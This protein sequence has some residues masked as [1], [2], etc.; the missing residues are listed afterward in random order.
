MDQY[1]GKLLDNRYEILDAI[2]VGGM[3]MVYKAYCHR[4]HRLVAV[5]ILR[6]DLAA[7]AEFRRR[8]HDEAQAV[9]MLSHANIVS[10]YDVSRGEDLEYIVMELIDG[11]TLKQYMKKKGGKLTWRESLHYITQIIRALG[12]AHGRG[13]IHRDIKP[14]NIM[15]LRDGS[16]RVAD[17]GIA[18]VMSAAQNTLTQ[19]ALGSVHYI[20]PEQAR[21]SHL[22]ERADIYSAGVVLYE[23]LTGR[24]PFEGDSPVSVAIQHISAIPLAPRELND[25]IPEALESITLKAMSSNVERRY[26]NAD[27]MIRDL[28]EFRKNPNIDFGYEHHGYPQSD[29]PTQVLDTLSITGSLGKKKAAPRQ[30]QPF[31]VDDDYEPYED[32]HTTS[33]RRVVDQPR[34]NERQLATKKRGSMAPVIAVISIF[35]L[36]V[37]IFLWVFMGDLFKT[38]E[39]T[40]IPS[41]VGK[42]LREVEADATLNGTFEIVVEK[43]E[44]SKE[45]DEGYIIAQSPNEGTEAR[46][47]KPKI[48]LTVSSGKAEVKMPDLTSKLYADAK[49]ALEALG[50][51]LQ[52]STEYLHDNEIETEHVISTLPLQGSPLSAGNKVTLI[53]SRGKEEKQVAVPGVTKLSQK[54]AE[55]MLKNMGL[56]PKV[57][58]YHNERPAGEVFQQN[59]N[60]T[61]AVAPNSTVTIY[62]SKGPA[63]KSYTAQ[64]TIPTDGE[65]L[66]VRVT[67]AGEDQY[68]STVDTSTADGTLA[69]P[70]T[71]TGEQEIVIYFNETEA[72]RYMHNFSE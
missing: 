23:M 30:S 37:A 24:L 45:Y 56:V 12:H 28:E 67:V 39:V 70:L 57:E 36:G 26:K 25:E 69:V 40:R 48:T 44:A 6:T 71:G 5:K 31:D 61:T 35:I 65:P 52:I 42:V 64:L 53:L 60:S 22:D 29:E 46:G 14:Q 1:I 10:V 33:S 8:F 9:A 43:R 19:E 17:F 41:L 51:D 13:I 59:P 32:Y 21:G 38:P 18:R 72:D 11:I 4:L 3:A 7:D 68:D 63:S 49:I 34:R 55:A 15:V 54:D 47:E 66:H 58:S 20:S 27:E 2:G 62:V 50:L 16:V